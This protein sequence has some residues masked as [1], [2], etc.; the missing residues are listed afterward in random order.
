MVSIETFYQINATSYPYDM[1][2]VSRGFGMQ[3]TTLGPR[4][5][6]GTAD[7]MIMNYNR[8]DTA[9]DVQI[10]YAHDIRYAWCK[11]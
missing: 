6:R 2:L 10:G 11:T 7:L 8:I 3:T 5:D 9:L 4:N 1:P